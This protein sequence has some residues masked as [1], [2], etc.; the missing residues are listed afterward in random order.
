VGGRKVEVLFFSEV[1]KNR[2]FTDAEIEIL[3]VGS[4]NGRKKSI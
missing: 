2:H 1:L 4:R 3:Y